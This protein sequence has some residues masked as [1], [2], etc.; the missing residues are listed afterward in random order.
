M[1]RVVKSLKYL[2]SNIHDSEGGVRN[3]FLTGLELMLIGLL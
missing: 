3:S 2:S 1:R